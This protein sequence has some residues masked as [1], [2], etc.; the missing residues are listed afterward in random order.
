[1]TE[2]SLATIDDAYQEF[3]DL[4]GSA[5]PTWTRSNLLWWLLGEDKDIPYSMNDVREA[6][7]AEQEELTADIAA[8]RS[9]EKS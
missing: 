9:S 8:Q 5:T 4:H 7:D 2:K 3:R 1:V 6:Y